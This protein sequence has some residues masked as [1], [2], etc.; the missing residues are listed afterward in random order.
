MKNKN[1]IKEL[2]KRISKLEKVNSDNTIVS[3]MESVE[4]EKESK[5]L[6]EKWCVECTQENSETLNKYLHENKEKY[7]LYSQFWR[8]SAEG[9]FV[10]ENQNGGHTIAYE[11]P[12]GYTEITFDQFKKWVLKEDD[13]SFVIPQNISEKPLS[14]REVQVKVTSQEEANECAEIAKGCGEKVK[15]FELIFVY[16]DENHNYFRKNNLMENFV[17]GR[18]VD[19]AKEISIEQYRELFGKKQDT[20]IDWSKPWQYVIS[21]NNAVWRTTGNH[22]DRV[23]EGLL[24]RFADNT[25]GNNTLFDKSTKVLKKYFKLCTEPITLKN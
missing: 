17:L 10:S 3:V 21:E 11:F 22:N 13:L 12:K 25:G 4:I 1:K 14:I 20:E 23:F 6:P 16:G 8:V 9:Y 7:R 19:T 18:K 5:E 2:E 24:I 15:K